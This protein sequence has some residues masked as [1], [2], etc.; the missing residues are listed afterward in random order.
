MVGKIEEGAHADLLLIDGNPL[1]D[2]SILEDPEAVLDLIMKAG[3][4]YKNKL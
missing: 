1:Q 3:V 2:I 4:I